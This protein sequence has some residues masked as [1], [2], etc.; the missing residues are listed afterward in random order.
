VPFSFRPAR[1][2]S[3]WLLLGVC[4]GTG[5]GKTYS[6]LRLA[7][8]IANG[9][10]IAGI[11]S[12]NGR[13]E[14]YADLFPE[15][16]VTQIEAPFRPDKYTDAIEAAERYLI[17]IGV[18][19]ENRVTLVDSASHEWYGEGGC[20]E[21]HDELMG[22]AQNLNLTAWIEPKKAHKR[23]VN[24]LLQVSSHVILCFRAEPKVEAV[25]EGGR[26]VIKPKES[27]VGLDGWLPIAEKNL[28]FELTTFFLLMADQ[29][30][31][32]KPI[33]L[34]EQHRALFPLDK[35]LTEASGAEM[36]RWAKGAPPQSWPDRI[37]GAPDLRALKLLEESI[38][39]AQI[40]EPQLEV[41]RGL[42]KDRWNELAKKKEG[43]A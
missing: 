18:P 41:L 30:G 36:A 17:E 13:M 25:R 7:R 24:R 42:F 5:S 14:H 8:G 22:G 16:R 3:I 20:L 2:S 11:D 40:D 38:K 9:H 26:L 27:L 37:A 15:L 34:Q 10:P 1:R 35:P 32:P 29:P 31:V 19:P 12:E 43:A 4:G 28:P 21:W 33:K 23:M 39:S 6:A